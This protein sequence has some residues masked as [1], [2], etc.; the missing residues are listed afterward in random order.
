MAL[1]RQFLVLQVFSHFAK[2]INSRLD[3]FRNPYQQLFT[4][5]A[6]LGQGNLHPSLVHSRPLLHSLLCL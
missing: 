3:P 5:A 4:G 2:T 6:G 1:F